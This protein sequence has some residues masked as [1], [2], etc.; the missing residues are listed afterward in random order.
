[1]Y[2]FQFFIQKFDGD[3]NRLLFCVRAR[4]HAI[5]SV[6]SGEGEELLMTLK[7]QDSRNGRVK[8]R[9]RTEVY[10]RGVTHNFSGRLPSREDTNP[11]VIA[12]SQ[13]KN[14]GTRHQ[15]PG[16]EAQAG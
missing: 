10:L 1:M 3:E 2:K 5:M 7:S 13:I 12:I 14:K 16:T 9:Q 4:Q 11:K 15:A 8:D 6:M